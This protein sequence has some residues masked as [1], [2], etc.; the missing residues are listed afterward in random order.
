MRALGQESR[1]DI[2][3]C[4]SNTPA[5]PEHM[6]TLFKY[7][8]SRRRSGQV[9][10]FLISPALHHRRSAFQKAGGRGEVGGI[11]CSF[12]WPGRWISSLRARR[13][14]WAARMC[15]Y[16]NIWAKNG[17]ALQKIPSGQFLH[18]DQGGRQSTTERVGPQVFSQFALTKQFPTYLTLQLKVC[19]PSSHLLAGRVSP[20]AEA[21]PRSKSVG[22]CRRRGARG[23]SGLSKHLCQ[24][25]SI[26]RTRD[27]S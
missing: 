27:V 16:Y 7:D 1:Q 15:H 18:R 3:E 4:Y 17:S 5:P 14:V 20:V 22:V 19:N 6:W 8:Q 9:P 10:C 2:T 21:V 11:C 26:S 25:I 23:G 13:E 24:F 12:F